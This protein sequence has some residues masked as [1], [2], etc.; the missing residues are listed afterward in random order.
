MDKGR[1]GVGGREGV[2]DRNKETI[3]LVHQ[4]SDHVR[5]TCLPI[6]SLV[7]KNCAPI[8]AELQVSQKQAQ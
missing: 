1:D 2:R 6:F 7:Q 4:T 8:N 3:L 5:L